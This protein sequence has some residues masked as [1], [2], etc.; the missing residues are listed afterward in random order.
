MCLLPLAPVHTPRRSPP[1]ANYQYEPFTF[2]TGY[3]KSGLVVLVGF[4]LRAISIDEPFVD[5]WSYRQ[6]DVAMVARNFYQ[7]RYDILH[8]RIDYGGAQPG[9]VGMEFPVVP[10]LAAALFCLLA[11]TKQ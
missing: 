10:F 3:E 5:R 2:A 6:S 4:V 9:Y 11:S 8:P 1:S 7:F